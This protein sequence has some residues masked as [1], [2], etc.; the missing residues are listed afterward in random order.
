MTPEFLDN[1]RDVTK[2]FFELPLEQ[3]Q[4]CSQ[5]VGDIQGYVNEIVLSEQ[6][7]LDWSER[8]YLVIQPE[9]RRNLKLWPEKPEDFR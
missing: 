8:L 3:K 1:V 4:R 9:D 5:E 6:E 2:Q 7:K